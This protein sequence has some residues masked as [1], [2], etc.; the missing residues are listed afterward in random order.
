MKQ[1]LLCDCIAHIGNNCRP[2]TLAPRKHTKNFELAAQRQRQICILP[3]RESTCSKHHSDP[4][5]CCN[6]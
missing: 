5:D 2:Q 6:I 3:N 4:N 1:I